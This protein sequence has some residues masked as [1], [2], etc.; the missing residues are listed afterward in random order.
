[1]GLVFPRTARG[2]QRYVKNLSIL[3]ICNAIRPSFREKLQQ[4]A[5]ARF[6]ICSKFLNLLRMLVAGGGIEPPTLG[7]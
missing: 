7:L 6:P 4:L 1:M 2:A 3:N 5:R